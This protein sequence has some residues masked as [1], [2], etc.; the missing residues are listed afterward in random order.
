MNMSKIF[1]VR[2]KEIRNDLKITQ[3]ELAFKCDMQPSHI[4]QLERGIKN[5]TLD[6]LYKI[7]VGI[8]V[9]ISELVNFDNKLVLPN[10][11][12]ELTNKIMARI[13]KLKPN[14]KNQILSIVKTFTDKR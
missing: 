3:E 7:S 5:P 14:E 4:G 2:L 6:T 12:D 8:E 10:N 9:S 11:M 13:Q 1:G